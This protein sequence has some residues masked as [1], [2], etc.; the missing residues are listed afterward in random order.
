MVCFLSENTSL[1][2]S[3]CHTQSIDGVEIL[4][5]PQICDIDTVSHFRMQ[6]MEDMTTAD[7]E[8]THGCK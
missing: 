4:A 2:T 5:L 8:V 1:G 6:L 7:Q 3:A